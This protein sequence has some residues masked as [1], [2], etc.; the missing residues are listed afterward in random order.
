MNVYDVQTT[1]K[2]VNELF[3]NNN[4]LN[5]IKDSTTQQSIEEAQELVNLLPSELASDFQEAISKAQR[6]LDDELTMVP[7]VL[8]TVYVNSNEIVVKGTPSAKITLSL[9]NGTQIT[10]TIDSNGETCFNL[11]SLKE[12]DTIEAFQT[13]K[14]VKGKVVS[15]LVRAI[16]IKAQVVNNYYMNSTYVSGTI[17]EGT[18]KIALAID[19][20]VIRYG[21]INQNGTYKIYAGDVLL[22]PGQNFT[23]IPI[24]R[25][26]TRRSNKMLLFKI[27]E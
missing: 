16:E 11:F 19:G 25:N 10:N 13:Y 18:T 4:V 8:S 23:I 27:I 9:P 20:L 1:S 7:L 2:I 3:V 21:E 26:G 14:G 5:S 22:T 12:G 6:E 17:S 24:G 15:T